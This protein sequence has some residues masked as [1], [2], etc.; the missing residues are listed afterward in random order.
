MKYRKG[1]KYQLAEDEIFITDI[2][3]GKDV[4]TQFISLSEDGVLTIKSGYAWDGPSGPTFDRKTN[5]RGSLAH[6]ALYQ[7]IRQKWL[8]DAWRK[9]ADDFIAKC[10][11]EDGMWKWL[12]NTEKFALKKFAS[13]AADP[14]NA[15]KVYE[16][17]KHIKSK[18]KKVK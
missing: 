15:K 14:K 12:A 7:L 18:T 9:K 8:D 16:A 13:A 5:M 11:I 2:C 10:W 6:D 4:K 1:Y 3:G 17:P